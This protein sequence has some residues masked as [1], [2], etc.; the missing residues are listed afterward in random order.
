M[1]AHRLVFVVAIASVMSCEALPVVVTDLEALSDAT[2]PDA[3]ARKGKARPPLLANTPIPNRKEIKRPSPSPTPTATPTP[4][5][6]PALISRV[7]EQLTCLTDERVGDRFKVY[8][9]PGVHTDL[10]VQLQWTLN[11]MVA[12]MKAPN[13]VVLKAGEKTLVGELRFTSSAGGTYQVQAPAVRYGDMSVTSDAYVYGLPWR[14]GETYTCGNGWNG[15]GAHQGDYGYAVDFLMPEGTPVL[16]S[17]DGVVFATESRFSR[18]G[19]DRAL[20]DQ[21]NYVYIRH[22]NGTY[23]RYLHFKQGGVAVQ[24]GQPVRR[25]QLIGYSGNTGWS[26]D[27][28]LH[29]DVMTAKSAS[30]DRT[31]GVKFQ[32]QAGQPA[33]EAPT[34][35]KAYTAF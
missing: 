24:V 26:T 15:F 2:E 7:C 21:A 11:G 4:T 35:G 16:A 3:L 20:A 13:P 14:A 28:H 9:Q 6:S 30:A 8:L 31:I 29:F 5:P 25:G 27:P 34:K 12:D 1:R 19:N 10:T 33:G 17:R 23:G 32:T 22:D 18:G